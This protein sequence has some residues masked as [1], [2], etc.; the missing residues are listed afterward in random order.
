MMDKD[1]AQVDR[2]LP[3]RLKHQ[4]QTLAHT[5]IPLGVVWAGSAILVTGRFAPL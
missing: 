4:S 1:T 3:P 2:G 5:N